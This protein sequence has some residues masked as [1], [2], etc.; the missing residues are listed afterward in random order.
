MKSKQ[1][2]PGTI[3]QPKKSAPG[4]V[5]RLGLPKLLLVVNYY[6]TMRPSANIEDEHYE[7]GVVELENLAY[8]EYTGYVIEDYYEKA[9]A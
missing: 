5:L 3:L 8:N 4:Y 9:N 1:I 2:L 7:Y 6:A